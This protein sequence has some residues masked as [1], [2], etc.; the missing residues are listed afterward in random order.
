MYG[1][2][3]HAQLSSS[4]G[5]GMNILSGASLHLVQ[6]ARLGRDDER[7]RGDFAA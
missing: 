5:A 2:W 6:D 7:L 1:H 4:G 3:L